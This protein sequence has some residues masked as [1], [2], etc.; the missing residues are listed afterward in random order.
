[1]AVYR[2]PIEFG[3]TDFHVDRRDPAARRLLRECDPGSRRDA[4]GHFNRPRRSRR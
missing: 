2:L 4:A 1:M 3:H